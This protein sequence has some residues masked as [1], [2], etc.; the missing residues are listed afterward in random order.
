MHDENR[1]QLEMRWVP[2]T[3]ERG[4]PRME[5]IWIAASDVAA[6]THAA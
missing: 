2:V 4:R 1:P 5:A 6:V 3:D